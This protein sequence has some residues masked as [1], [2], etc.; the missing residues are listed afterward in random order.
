MP[1]APSGASISYGPNR[2][3]RSRGMFQFVYWAEYIELVVLQ[4]GK[5]ATT[6][7]E[8]PRSLELLASLAIASATVP[9]RSP[10]S[11]LH[12]G[13]PNLLRRTRLAGHLSTTAQLRPTRLWG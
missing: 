10:F 8:L 12:R 1:P 3:P 5:G 11:A 9:A 4:A 2:S 7:T 6:A 13:P